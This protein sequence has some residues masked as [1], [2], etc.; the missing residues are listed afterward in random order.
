VLAELD[1]ELV[2]LTGVKQ[3]IAEIAALLAVDAA[4]EQFGLSNERPSLHMSF[5]G[6]PGTGKTTTV[7]GI[8][9]VLGRAGLEV[10]LGA[11]TGRAAKRLSEVTRRPAST[12][13]RLLKYD[14]GEKRFLHDEADPLPCDAL[15]VDEVSMIDTPLMYALL[16]AVGQGTR[17]ILLGDPDQLPSVGPGKVL[18]ELIRSRAVPHLHLEAVFRQAEASPI[19][20]NAHRIR[21]GE[22]PA[23]PRPAEAK[24]SDS[25][26]WFVPC[27]DAAAG[28]SLVADLVCD[29]LPGRFGYHPLRD[30]QVLSPMNQG[31]LGTAALN[32]ALQAR[33][34]PFS[35]GV[36]H[37]DRV[38]R[39]RDKVMQLRN[40]YDKGVFNGDV[41]Y[42]RSASPARR[43][44]TVDFDG[45]EVEYEGEELD[46]LALAYAVSVHKSQ[47]S[48]FGSV[49]L[50]LPEP[51][52]PLLTRELFYTAVTRAQQK[53]RI[54][55]TEAAIRA[56][57]GRE[58]QRASGLRDRL[59]AALSPEA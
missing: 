51:S 16:K 23:F 46:Q 49:T 55:G 52:S 18:A 30:I 56:A 40:N 9:E 41:G 28:V 44:V 50:V 6:G 59:R 7:L 43:A 42:V 29:R 57:V 11:P 1:A 10:R 24:P 19:I 34:N 14:P 31:P 53:V 54:V 39:V 8:L 32:Q 15:V 38:L 45:E 17:L 48:Q 4:R 22:P 58:V 3:R 36:E 5:T 12:L 37:R 33:L 35:E 13:H 47:G 21:R 26:F 25:G 20:A 2:G 27:P